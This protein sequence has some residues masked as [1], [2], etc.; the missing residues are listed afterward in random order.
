MSQ[1][2]VMQQYFSDVGLLVCADEHL[3]HTGVLRRASTD[4]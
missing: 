1:V 2:H 3:S 4:Y